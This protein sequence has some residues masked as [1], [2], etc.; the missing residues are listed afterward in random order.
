MLPGT[1]RGKYLLTL[2]PDT[3]KVFHADDKKDII[4]IDR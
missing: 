2:L 1:Y 3:Q 4:D